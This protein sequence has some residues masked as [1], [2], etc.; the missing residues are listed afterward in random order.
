MTMRGKMVHKFSDLAD[1]QRKEAE[2]VRLRTEKANVADY[3]DDRITF[4]RTGQI[5]IRRDEHSLNLGRVARAAQRIFEATWERPTN[6]SWI[7]PVWRLVQSMHHMQR[8]VS[9]RVAEVVRAVRARIELRTTE[10]AV[11]REWH[12]ER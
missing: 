9:E 7:I 6:R 1:E 5:E 8:Q 2:V 12:L 10:R 11:T 4:M 3:V